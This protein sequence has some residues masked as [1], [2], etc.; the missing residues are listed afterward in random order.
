MLHHKLTKVEAIQPYF[1]HLHY[2][3]GEIKTFDVSPYITGSWYGEL[4]N[5]DYFITVQ[6]LPDGS[7]IRWP[8]GQDIAPHELYD[9]STKIL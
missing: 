5:K 6:L 2:T 1:L 8:N 3:S 9:N 7:G 4:S